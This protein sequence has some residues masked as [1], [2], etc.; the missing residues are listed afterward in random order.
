MALAELTAGVATRVVGATN[1]PEGG[2]F[3]V[4]LVPMTSVRTL[5]LLV[6]FCYRN[7]E[8]FD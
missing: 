3:A 7:D 6:S 8:F 2:A 1:L 4:T 5:G